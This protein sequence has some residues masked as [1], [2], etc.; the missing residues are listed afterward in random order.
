MEAGEDGAFVVVVVVNWQDAASQQGTYDLL[1]ADISFT[2]YDSCTIQDLWT[3]E[4]TKSN[5][6]VQDWGVIEP[7]AHVAKKIKCLPF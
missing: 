4:T 5:G 3:G 2:K 6:S 7:H 1:A